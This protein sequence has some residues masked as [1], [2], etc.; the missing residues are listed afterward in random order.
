[1]KRHLWLVASVVVN[2]VLLAALATRWSAVRPSSTPPPSP[3]ALPPAS[4]GVPVPPVVPAQG[5]P[6]GSMASAQAAEWPRW[7]PQLRAAGVSEEILAGLVIA[8]FDTRWDQRLGYLQ[9]QYE[10]GAIEQTVV[11][12]AH[13][14]GDAEQEQELRLA[15]GDEGF[16]RW[17]QRNLLREFAPQQLRLTPAEGDAI[18]DLRRNL[19]VQRRGLEQANQRGEIDDADLADRLAAVETDYHARLKPLLGEERYAILNG[20]DAEPN[21][22]LRRQLQNVAVSPAQLNALADVRRASDALNAEIDRQWDES[23]TRELGFEMR[24]LALEAARDR[25]YERVLGSEKFAE[26]K[27]AN[28]AR[29]QSLKR[30]AETWR[31]SHGELENL[32]ATLQNYDRTVG[33]FRQQAFLA[34]QKG[35]PV[36]WP[37]LQRAITEFSQQLEQ[38]IRKSLGDERFDRL[39]RSAVL[40]FDQ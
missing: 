30:F 23:P 26:F 38:S 18:Y 37:D 11:A 31:I 7:L 40:T 8:D 15:L 25:E 22:D 21:A 5:M 3:T 35:Q 19:I 24:R 17:E 20:A 34:E 39:K 14:L 33:D 12:H 13:N 6:L 32:Y 36:D 1:M 10:A 27:K 2:V 4:L 28:D 29:Y 16:R 9:R